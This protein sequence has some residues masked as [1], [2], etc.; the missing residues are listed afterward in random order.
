MAAQ[1]TPAA[2]LQIKRT[3]SA[4]REKVFEAWTKEEALRQW[5]CHEGYTTLSAEADLREGGGYRMV[6]KKDGDDSDPFHVEGTYEA[7][8]PPEKLV[9]TWRWSHMAGM[10]DTR[11]TVELHDAGGSTELVLTHELFQSEEL[12]NEHNAGW[13]L[14]LK[15]LA[16][17]LG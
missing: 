4:P 2:S 3:F 12:R 9:F 10:N 1:S 5:F 7:V 17:H 16:A 15:S 11:V 6:M 8:V 13:D 14:V